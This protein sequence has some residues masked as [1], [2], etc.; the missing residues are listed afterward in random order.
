[1][2]YGGTLCEVWPFQSTRDRVAI[3]ASGSND[4]L[5][6]GA[7]PHFFLDYF[8]TGRIDADA[9]T[10]V[11]DG[12]V[13]ACAAGDMDGARALHRQLTPWMRAAFVESN[14]VPLKAALAMMGKM[15]NVVRL[16]LVP[17]A[18]AHTAAVRQ[19]LAAA[20]VSF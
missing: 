11:V 17:L 2:S 3:A 5:V 20:G 19:A 18:D 1:M 13:D 10:R 6:L 16:P 15:Q 7:R 12:L 8:G 14:P 9:M 4:I